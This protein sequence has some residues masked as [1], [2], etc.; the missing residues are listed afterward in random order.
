MRQLLISV[1]IF[2][3]INGNARVFETDVAPK[4]KV[5]GTVIDEYSKKPLE[6]ATVALYSVTGNKLI[7]G[8]VTD[9]LGQF[10]IEKPNAGEYYLE[11]TFIGLKDIKSQVFKIE[12][13][14]HNVNLGNFFLKSA[15]KELG[16]VEVVSKK[17]P[18]EYK[19]DKKVINVDKQLTSSSGTA[20][21]ILENVPSVQVDIEGNVSLR[22]STGFT[23]LIDGK[24]TILEPS[25]ALRQIPSG[26]IENIEII[27]NPSVKYEPDG[28]TGIINIITKKNYLEGLSGSVNLN[29]GMYDQYGADLQLNYRTN[30]FNF[31]LGANYRKH[32]HP[33]SQTSERKTYSDDTTYF[34]NSSGDAERG[35]TGKGIRAGIEYNPTKR[36]FISLAGRFGNWS[37][38]HDANLQY[39][40][41]TEPATFSDTY[42]SFDNTVRGGNYFS[43]D[44]VYQ[45]DFLK[46]DTVK[47]ETRRQNGKTEPKQLHNIKLEVN[48]RY[49]D[50][51]E[52]S[53]SELRTLTDSIT[54]GTKNIENG[55]SKRLRIN[56]DYSL[57]V[58][59]KDKFESGFQ[60]RMGRSVDITGFDTLN[61]INNEWINIDSFNYTTNYNRNI[62]AIYALY[63]GMFGK[64]GYQAGLRGEYT[65]RTVSTTGRA[66][67][68]L[69]RWDY[70]PTLHLSYNLPLDQ[71]LM[72][73]YS[74]R[75]DRPRGWYLEPFITWQDKYNV[76]RG[77]PD[78][79]PEYIDSYDI[80]YLIKFKENFFS[81]E[82]YYRV[83][84]NKVE[85][86]TSVYTKNVMLHTLENVGQDYSLG[87]EAM[88]NLNLFKWWEMDLSGNLYN[89]KLKGTLYDEPFNRSSFNWNSRLSNTFNIW[90]N[91]QLQVNSRYNSKSVTAQGTRYGYYTVDAAFKVNFLDRRLS[92]NLQARDIFGTAKREYI[93]EG[94]DFYTHDKYLPKTPML[95]LT[96]S[97][98]F[99]NFKPSKRAAGQNGD[100]Q[101]DEF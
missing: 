66:D 63:A 14:Q 1:F 100:D 36:D 9:Y 81:L 98:R 22:G 60:V 24:P 2:L 45:H 74:R 70:F 19:I 34:V 20:V 16:E 40:N 65:D 28:A 82:G 46:N 7:T 18:I 57:P 32:S 76:R 96:I 101:E 39:Q 31:I 8:S 5:K 84:H 27:T 94:Q 13:G 12:D 92:A 11:I 89:Y 21:D 49:H 75:I 48:Y 67:F 38:H 44:G 58:G 79:K 87:V 93:S 26:S 77:N 99:N 4:G 41:R 71:Q 37:M 69:N 3:F 51:D 23:V 47:S 43:A 15:S 83:T 25:D 33:G 30:K 97:Y 91:G 29:A 55:P 72:M 61:P 80:G 62:Y 54:G 64:F 50:G 35:H 95:M 86:T 85:R 10:K 73:S 53:I 88:L 42:N 52:Y 59:K 17:A 56:L 6:Y 90:K 78:L 68:K